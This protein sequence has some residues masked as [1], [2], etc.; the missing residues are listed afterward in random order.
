MCS[1]SKIQ[2]PGQISPG[3]APSW[4]VQRAYLGVLSAAASIDPALAGQ[5]RKEPL[6]QAKSV[7]DRR[8]LRRFR[9]K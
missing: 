6:N 7:T 4:A 5:A 9:A 8:S 1:L 2:L 3:T